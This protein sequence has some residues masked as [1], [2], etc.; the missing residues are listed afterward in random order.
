MKNSKRNLI[1]MK[2]KI[3]TINQEKD[4]SDHLYYPIMIKIASK[5]KLILVG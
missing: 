2:Y 5:S 1:R 4:L 3:L